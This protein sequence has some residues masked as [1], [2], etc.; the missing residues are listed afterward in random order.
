MLGFT[1]DNIR[2][3]I[4]ELANYPKGDF[5][6]YSESTFCGIAK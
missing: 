1:K 5:G 2:R 6:K 4:T 3:Q